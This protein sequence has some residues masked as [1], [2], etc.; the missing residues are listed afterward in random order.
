MNQYTQRMYTHSYA[1]TRH[2][3]TC[4]YAHMDLLNSSPNVY[5]CVFIWTKGVSANDE[6][7]MWPQGGCSVPGD[8]RTAKFENKDIYPGVCHGLGHSAINHRATEDRREPGATFPIPVEDVPVNTLTYL[9]N[10]ACTVQGALKTNPGN[11]MTLV[12]IWLISKVLILNM[13]IQM[14]STLTQKVEH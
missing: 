1:H 4:T 11:T 3:H 5:G 8:Y 12:Q 14:V 2:M 7:K 10:C 6:D 13:N 9:S